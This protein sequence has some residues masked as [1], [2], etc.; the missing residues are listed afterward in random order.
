MFL[1]IKLGRYPS[2]KKTVTVQEVKDLE[3]KKR[4]EQEEQDLKK[5][6]RIAELEALVEKM[7]AVEKDDPFISLEAIASFPEMRKKYHVC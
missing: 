7:V 6:K 1:G 2:H 5:Q 4:Q 3:A